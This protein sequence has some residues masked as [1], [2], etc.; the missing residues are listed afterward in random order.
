MIFKLIMIHEKQFFIYLETQ[1]AQKKKI[2]S[3]CVNVLTIKNWAFS[4][5]N[6]SAPEA[7]I[8]S[9]FC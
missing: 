1:A 5:N 9:S 2:Q 8:Q 7:G 3:T 6:N 4:Q